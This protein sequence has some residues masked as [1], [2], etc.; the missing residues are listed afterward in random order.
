M[1]LTG[2]ISVLAC[3]A[4]WNI[5]KQVKGYYALFLLLVASMMGVFV[6]LDLFL[7]YVFFEV[8]LLPMYFLIGIWGGGNREYAAIKFL[9]FTLFGSVFILVA[10]LILYF[11]PGDSAAQSLFNATGQAQAVHRP[12]VRH[13]RADGDRHRD[14]LLRPR[15]P[16]LGVHPLLHRLHRS[17]CRRSR[18]TPGFPTPTWTRPT[19]ISMILAGILLKIGGYGLIRLA[20]PLAPARCLRLGLLRGRRSGRLQHPLRGPGGDGPDRLQE[21]GRLQ[22]GQPHGLR[23]PRAWPR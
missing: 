13:R 15:D 11:W 4:S 19:P 17:S 14:R 18:S 10:V 3:L 12:L 5:T 9:L 2:L 23:H 6:S 16:V 22:L 21:A 8:M 1:V 7:F 20:W